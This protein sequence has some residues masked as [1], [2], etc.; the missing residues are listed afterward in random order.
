MDRLEIEK[1]RIASQERIAGMQTGAKIATDEA[2][3]SS[4]QQEAGMRLGIDLARETA[5]EDQAMRQMQQNQQQ[6]RKEDE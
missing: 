6:P 2:N 3:L 1:E 5:Q 4:K